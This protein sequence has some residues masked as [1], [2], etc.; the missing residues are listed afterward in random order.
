MQPLLLEHRNGSVWLVVDSAMPLTTPGEIAALVAEVGPNVPV[1]GIGPEL[2]SIAS[3][4]FMQHAF[5]HDRHNMNAL[6]LLLEWR[7]DFPPVGNPDPY[8]NAKISHLVTT[9]KIKMFEIKVEPDITGADLLDYI[10]NHAVDDII[11]FATEDECAA[12]ELAGLAVPVAGNAADAAAAACYALK[13]ELV[14]AL[15]STA[16]IIVPGFIQA[17]IVAVRRGRV[18][19]QARA[20]RRA[21]ELRR[22]ELYELFVRSGRQAAEGRH[23]AKQRL[24]EIGR[25]LPVGV[26]PSRG[27]H[28]GRGNFSEVYLSSDGTMVIKEIRSRIGHPGREME[29]SPEE[30]RAMAQRT[31]EQ[32]EYLRRAGFPVPKSWVPSSN[33]NVVVQQRA[34]GVRYEQLSED[35]KGHARGS[36]DGLK[37]LALQDRRVAIDRGANFQDNMAFDEHGNVTAWY[38][39]AMPLDSDATRGISSRAYVNGAFGG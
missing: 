11:A 36:A 3:R 39:P 30:I 23:V 37:S 29:V 15:I 24:D 25:N 20:A 34:P 27:E 19:A 31:V 32:H 22:R 13:G 5:T 38:D 4:I 2:S 28:I 1:F 21:A 9:G 26:M 12:L 35:V 8:V 16:M 6:R 10:S 14:N 18:F 17:G 33:P 7:G